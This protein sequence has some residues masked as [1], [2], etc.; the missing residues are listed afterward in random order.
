MTLYPYTA[1][2]LFQEFASRRDTYADNVKDYVPENPDES[3]SYLRESI[4]NLNDLDLHDYIKE[5]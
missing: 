3:L 2:F 4:L 5:T 1:A